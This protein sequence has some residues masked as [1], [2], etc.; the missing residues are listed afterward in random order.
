MKYIILHAAIL[1][2]SGLIWRVNQLL[3]FFRMFKKYRNEYS[4]SIFYPGN[5]LHFK[6]LLKSKFYP[7]KNFLVK[8]TG[9]F[10]ELW[11]NILYK[12]KMEIGE[13]CPYGGRLF[14]AV[15]EGI[16]LV[17]ANDTLKKQTLLH[18]VD[19]I[20]REVWYVYEYKAVTVGQSKLKGA[21][22]IYKDIL[23]GFHDND[24]IFIDDHPDNAVVVGGEVKLIDLESLLVVKST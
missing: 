13:R 8:T 7:E 12:W 23:K 14:A 3:V 15:I 6:Y 19:F 17:N 4:I 11:E 10:P 5:G 20:S 21:L 16:E 22:D 24:L 1:P 18:D 9:V 2:F